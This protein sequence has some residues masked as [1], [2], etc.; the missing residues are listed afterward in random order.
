MTARASA[1]TWE[2]SNL[3]PEHTSTFDESIQRPGK[4]HFHKQSRAKDVCVNRHRHQEFQEQPGN[5]AS[6]KLP[7]VCYNVRNR[8][9]G[10]LVPVRSPVSQTDEF[11]LDTFDKNTHGDPE[12]EL[13]S[14]Y[15]SDDEIDSW[16]FFCTTGGGEWF[17]FCPNE[18]T[19]AKR[20]EVEIY[21]LTVVPGIGL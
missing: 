10:S 7:M 1:L 11:D 17:V 18:K 20:N 8:S 15:G 3:G 6:I 9:A 19:D 14:G 21:F 13:R 5:E 16:L 12:D 4:P 2:E